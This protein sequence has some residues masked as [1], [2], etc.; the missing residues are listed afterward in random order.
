MEDKFL[1]LMLSIKCLKIK[2]QIFSLYFKTHGNPN[3][4]KTAKIIPVERQMKMLTFSLLGNIC[5]LCIITTSFILF[6]DEESNYLL[7]HPFA[8][9]ENI[10]EFHDALYFQILTMT[11]VGL[12]D[13]YPAKMTSRI[14]VIFFIFIV[15][16][17]FSS[18]VSQ[19][20]NLKN[21]LGINRKVHYKNKMVYGNVIIIGNIVKNPLDLEYFLMNHYD[22]KYAQ[23]KPLKFIK[24]LLIL[25]TDEFDHD[26]NAYLNFEILRSNYKI[27]KI[28]CMKLQSTRD[29]S[30][31]KKK[32]LLHTS[33]IICFN[34][35]DR[36]Y[37]KALNEERNWIFLIGI[38]LKTYPHINVY[39]FF[40]T[41]LI[42][43]EAKIFNESA[44]YNLQNINCQKPLICSVIALSL[45]NDGIGSMIQHLLLT[46]NICNH[47]TQ[48]FFKNLG[49]I[50]AGDEKKKFWLEATFNGL[51][52]QLVSRKLPLFF[53]GE[54]FI[55]I[56]KF[57][58]FY[59]CKKSEEIYG[60][61]K[62]QNIRAILIGI[63]SYKL[64]KVLLN[65]SFY[66][67]QEHDKVLFIANNKETIYFFENLMQFHKQEFDSEMEYP[68]LQNSQQ[69]I[70]S[71]ILRYSQDKKQQKPD[72]EP[73]LI[74]LKHTSLQNQVKDHTI[75]IG[76]Q[77]EEAIDIT[78]G[79][80]KINKNRELV[81]F[82]NK[83]ID[84]FPVELKQ[85]KQ[86]II[87]YGQ[88]ADLSCLEA[89]SIMS[90]HKVFIRFTQLEN[91][92]NMDIFKIYRNIKKFYPQVNITIVTSDSR[93]LQYLDERPKQKKINWELW[94]MS[95]KGKYIDEQT[96]FHSLNSLIYYEKSISNCV[97]QML[98]VERGEDQQHNNITD[99][100]DSKLSSTISF[101]NKQLHFQQ[102]Q[103]N[104]QN[105]LQQKNALNPTIQM[106]AKDQQWTQKGCQELQIKSQLF[107][108]E[109]TQRSVRHIKQFGDL[110]YFL[111]NSK[112]P[113]IALAIIKKGKSQE[114][115]QKDEKNES[116][117]LQEDDAN[118]R[119]IL[120]REHDKQWEEKIDLVEYDDSI[121]VLNPTP[122][123]QGL[124][125]GDKIIVLGNWEANLDTFQKGNNQEKKEEFQNIFNKIKTEESSKNKK[126]LETIFGLNNQA[127]HLK[128]NG[129]ITNFKFE[130]HLEITK[131]I[132][133]IFKNY[134]DLSDFHKKQ[135]EKVLQEYQ[136]DFL[137][138]QKLEKVQSQDLP[139]IDSIKIDKKETNVEQKNL[140][141]F[142]QFQT[143]NDNFNEQNQN[144]SIKFTNDEEFNKYQ[145]TKQSQFGQFDYNNDFSGFD[146]FDQHF[147]QNQ[148]QIL[149]QESQ[150][151]QDSFQIQGFQDFQNENSDQNKNFIQDVEI[152]SGNDF[153]QEQSENDQND[154]Q[155][156]DQNIQDDQ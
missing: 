89:L 95:L 146:N 81:Y 71:L 38:I 116:N 25:S 145:S 125:E 52:N 3:P 84:Q 2:D 99:V 65:P 148:E 12:G 33:N 78:K 67:Y 57:F 94:P 23:E 1:W 69:I 101:Y 28:K 42:I 104:Q 44:K 48:N 143:Q 43:N 32:Q 96:I 46:H 17:L 72:R 75:I 123:Q 49:N 16:G 7:F 127:K 63:K 18:W 103:Q 4:D 64:K 106:Q 139:S 87:A 77:I 22:E 155:K 115:Y 126:Y 152:V 47:K 130:E 35:E 39:I 58:Y 129:E 150:E 51:N 37:E 36:N 83:Q 133:D 40:S 55:N 107:T 74:D 111:M 138:D 132:R 144:Q 19:L 11:T 86:L 154:D 61:R 153:V 73:L 82:F 60:Y 97:M 147:G 9:G 85:D 29:I 92:T 156:N 6:V 121:L 30:W 128:E 14:I 124:S 21:K 118:Q 135:K 59:S 140:D 149:K 53:I 141:D 93:V 102:N 56:A 98:G 117:Q 27:K 50:K 122:Y 90:A 134:K 34:S 100:N 41:S 54:S 20:L 80:R 120:N 110:Q 131:K 137:G 45:E 10:L 88:Y 8:D 76:M 13:I 113:L 66:R 62:G 24:Q 15:I 68:V 112:Y 79:V 5:A 26:P 31:I 108:L 142:E 119:V 114:N 109:M 136:K 70:N 105:Q 91:Q 151:K